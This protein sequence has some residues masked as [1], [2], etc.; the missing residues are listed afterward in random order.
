[1]NSRLTIQDLA[2]YLADY[3]GKERRDAELFLKEFVAVVTEGVFSDKLVKVKGLGT[4]KIVG[5]EKRES[6]HVNTGE[7]FVI[8]AHYKFSFLPDKELKELVN[9][10][11]SFFETTELN[12]DV[13]FSDLDQSVG[14]E[15]EG[16]A[17]DES[18]EELMPASASA[19]EPVPSELEPAPSEEPEPV[20]SEKPEPVPSEE[21]EPVP[22][23]ELESSEPEPA[24]SEPEPSAMASRHPQ[25]SAGRSVAGAVW[26]TAVVVLLAAFFLYTRGFFE[27]RLYPRQTGAVIAEETISVDLEHSLPQTDRADSCQTVTYP[28]DTLQE[29]E[30]PA[31]RPDT[32]P[33]V[34][35]PAEQSEPELSDPVLARVTIKVGDRLTLIA[36]KYYG[37][38]IFWVY[39]FEHNRSKI[40]NPNNIPIGT[41]IEIPHPRL[42]AIDKDDP[43][44]MEKAK[45]RQS[46][47]LTRYKG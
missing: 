27:N 31:H 14:E 33:A 24:S 40:A 43:D 28:A 8:P 10:P 2:G 45:R 3:T 20:P 18:V 26:L 32:L 4:F 29:E 11:F 30:A 36:R 41:T 46:E 38:K 7:R 34:Q 16:D 6:V 44:S 12:E 47:L 37:H 1:M 9:K 35:E 13:D 23:E 39:I 5:V 15:K 42:Y 25:P 21:P 17:E 22:S 19:E